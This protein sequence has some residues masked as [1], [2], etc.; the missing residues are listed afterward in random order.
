MRPEFVDVFVEPNP[1]A[2]E[3]SGQRFKAAG[4]AR[5]I[6]RVRSERRWCRVTGWS[7]EGDGSPCAANAIP[8]ED[9]GS[10]AA[11]LVHGGDWGVRLVPEDGSP[12][13]G[14]PYLLL[15]GDAVE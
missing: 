5:A 14:E 10:G 2:P 6:T 8:V 15:D 12:P 3:G 11:L 7:S 9:S 13:F 4:E 1:N